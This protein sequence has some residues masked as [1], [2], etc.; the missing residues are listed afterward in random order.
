M[1]SVSAKFK[2]AGVTLEANSIIV[3]IILLI[4]LSSGPLPRLFESPSSLQVPNDVPSQKLQASQSGV[5]ADSCS[6]CL[7]SLITGDQLYVWADQTGRIINIA[8]RAIQQVSIQG[9]TMAQVGQDTYLLPGFVDLKRFDSRFFDLSYLVRNGYEKLS[10]LPI[11]TQ[12]FTVGLQSKLSLQTGVLDETP[13]DLEALRVPRSH[14]SEVYPSLVSDLSLSRVVLDGVVKASIVPEMSLTKS[15]GSLN[16]GGQTYPYNG[17]GNSL[18]G[19]DAGWSQGF[20]GRGIKVA[21]LDTGISKTHPDFYYPNGTSKIIYEADYTSDH[22]PADLFGHGTWTASILAGTGRA[23]RGLFSGT[24]PDA[25]ILNIKV[26]DHTGSGYDSWILG[27]LQ[28]AINH[29]VNIISMS[30]GETPDS[31]IDEAVRHATENGIIVIT[32]AGN[33]GPYYFSVG[34]PAEEPSALAVGASDIPNWFGSPPSESLAWFSSSGPSNAFN[35]VH[36]SLNGLPF[37]AVKPDLVAPGWQIVG[38]RS[39]SSYLGETVDNVP[40]FNSDYFA[41]SGTSAAAP[42]A[43]GAV[44]ILKQAFPNWSNQLIMDDL[45]S[46]STLLNQGWYSGHQYQL[47]C[48]SE[49]YVNSS[50]PL[51]VYQQGSGRVNLTAALAPPLIVTPAKILLSDFSQSNS[52]TFKVYN[53]TDSY[54]SFDIHIA[55]KNMQTGIDAS[56]LVR[57]SHT[58][59]ALAPKSSLDLTAIIKPKDAGAGFYGGYI[60]LTASGNPTRTLSHAS[61][62]FYSLH[63]LTVQ[64]FDPHGFPLS[65]GI[66]LDAMRN[67]TWFGYSFYQASLAQLDQEGKATIP[68]LDGVNMV[69]GASSLCGSSYCVFY[70]A[71]SA[72]VEGLNTTLVIGGNGS[73]PVGFSPDPS[74]VTVVTIQSDFRYTGLTSTTP[75]GPLSWEL[76]IGV[77]FSGQN[78]QNTPIYATPTNLPD[79]LRISYEYM[80][81]TSPIRQVFYPEFEF[82]NIRT[83]MNIVANSTAMVQKEGL[84]GGSPYH[85]G[86]QYVASSPLMSDAGFGV[87]FLLDLPS[88]LTLYV[89]PHF[90]YLD[91]QWY[92]YS[93]YPDTNLLEVFTAGEAGSKIYDEMNRRPYYPPEL[94]QVLDGSSSSNAISY[95]LGPLTTSSQIPGE[96][97]ILTRGTGLLYVNNSRI[98]VTSSI[99]PFAGAISGIQGDTKIALLWMAESGL[100]FDSEVRI[101]TTFWVDDSLG[102]QGSGW[103]V[104]PIIVGLK[105]SQLD[106]DGKATNGQTL[107]HVTTAAPNAAPV[108]KMDVEYSTDNGHRWETLS[109]IRTSATYSKDKNTFTESLIQL[110]PIFYLPVSLRIHL[111]NNLRGETTLTLLNAFASRNYPDSKLTILSPSNGVITLTQAISIRGEVTS[112]FLQENAISISDPRFVISAWNSTDGTFAFTNSSTVNSGSENLTITYKS[113][114]GKIAS[115]SLLLH[116]LNALK[117]TAQPYT[118]LLVVAP[119]TLLAMLMLKLASKQSQNRPIRQGYGNGM[120]RI[121]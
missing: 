61:I 10:Y 17:T 113:P 31:I 85:Y 97:I 16:Y 44:A 118:L 68:V 55:L 96:H 9:Y 93:I 50:Y 84:Y 71:G 72:D 77:E 58:S 36:S 92:P 102:K 100:Q 99:Q 74:N 14:L 33:S 15:I 82:P 2:T 27:G 35:L 79:S 103:G 88:N 21:V 41:L 120:R 3:V 66:I 86:S 6:P 107:I 19:V 64:A 7:L 90:Q 81:R 116:F 117:P 1:S 109:T 12:A 70:A 54:I 39:A 95:Q 63:Y 115:T 104:P 26:L 45:L 108:S 91:T 5:S 23:S 106:E 13:T 25:Q 87:G 80:A 22:N 75:H 49:E 42:H 46:T 4:L 121:D 56:S 38:A 34:S 8:Q 29:H 89:S 119:T 57:L 62:G 111:S 110:P 94:I 69:L 73:I 30:L 52:G 48:C 59:A 37:F 18:M 98:Q 11:I 20:T 83:A 105:L 43:A 60:L 28:D 112:A 78:L 51:D 32:A 114:Y 67:L 24:A 101:N 40:G 47:G 53:P 65:G 76:S